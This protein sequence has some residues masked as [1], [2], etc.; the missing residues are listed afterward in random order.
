MELSRAQTS[1]LT[2]RADAPCHAYTVAVDPAQLTAVSTIAKEAADRAVKRLKA[3]RLKTLKT[4]VIYIAEQARSL[5]GLFVSAISGGNL[6]R[7]SSFLLNH[8][9]KKI[10]PDFIHLQEKPWLERGLG[11]VP[12]DGDGVLTHE[13]VFVEGGRL[14]QYCLGVY[15]AKKLGMKTTGN[16]G[17][18]HNLEIKT[19]N[20]DLSNLLKT[21]DTGLL[22]TEMMGNGINLLTGDY[23]RG[24]SGFWVENGEIQYPVE[25]VTVAGR[26]QDIF[27]RITDVGNDVDIRGNI[28]TG[29]LLI[30][31][32]TVAGN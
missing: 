15:S 17:G 7:K 19:G 21:M 5:L 30:E 14:H 22:I 24:V 9:D 27:M 20:M 26:L 10:F 12:F 11:S 28:R 6:Y 3:R 18:V 8:L 32:M 1:K 2:R 25:E 31:E 16:A 13:N 29:S 4:P 23:S